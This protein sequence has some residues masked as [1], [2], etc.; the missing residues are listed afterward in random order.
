MKVILFLA[1]VYALIFNQ[2]QHKKKQQPPQ[3][4]N[5]TQS[6]SPDTVKKTPST[7]AMYFVNYLNAQPSA[8]MHAAAK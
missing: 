6:F 4:L 8:I 1:A 5:Y 3:N 7:P 2:T